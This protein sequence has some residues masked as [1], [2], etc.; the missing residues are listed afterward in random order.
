MRLLV[1][2]VTNAIY[3][4]M[5]RMQDLL[6]RYVTLTKGWAWLVIL[7]T[8]L[9]G[10]ASYVVSTFLPPVYQASATLI[11]SEKS[12]D[13][14]SDNVYASELA[15]LTYAQLLTNPTILEPVIVHHPGIT[16]QQLNAMI[17]VNAQSDTQLIELDVKNEDAQL[18]TRLGDE[19]SQS[20][21]SYSKTELPIT[22]RIVPAKIPMTPIS[23]KPLSNA[24]TGALV[25]LGL[26]LTLII[27]F[28]WI[29]DL[30]TN[31][32][33]VQALLDMEV[34]TVI[35]QASLH[36]QSQTRKL[37]EIPTLVKGCQQLC[38]FLAAEQAAG[39]FKLVMVTSSLRGE[40]KTTV[41]MLLASLLASSGKN[42]LLVDANMRDP[43]LDQ[44]FE[45]ESK[46]GLSNALQ[47][48][49]ALTPELY[50]Q[51]CDIPTLYVLSAGAPSN[52]PAKLLQ[53]PIVDRFF[54]H[55]KEA[56]F[57]YIIIDAPPLLPVAD[58]QFL[59]LHVQ[60]ILLV[61]DESKT[62][63]RV[64]SRTGQVL[65]RFPISVRGVV[66]NKSSRDCF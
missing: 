12:A 58:A 24:V 28:E 55:L 59:A 14:V 26:A 64:L 10:A 62:P 44:R 51:T 19:I 45:I 29:D 36:Q 15:A 57:D 46:C 52:D 53:L 11:V 40:G 18:A 6:R 42:V 30:S 63:R 66:M 23:P 13:S 43:V 5:V 3:V 47:G 38:A 54:G 16:L 27:I 22:V 21:Q 9:C 39:P 17:S 32:D 31:A 41:A 48:D 7:S 4:R 60:A 25:G 49:G 33:E 50:S 1:D 37:E 20:F 34:L 8:V 56:Y 65:S 35:P 2:Y 61:I